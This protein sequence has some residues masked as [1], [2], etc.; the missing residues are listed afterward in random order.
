MPFFNEKPIFLIFNCLLIRFWL[1]YIFVHIP[2]STMTWIRVYF[3]E[4]RIRTTEWAIYVINCWKWRG[5]LRRDEI[6][7]NFVMS[8]LIII[9]QSISSLIWLFTVR[10]TEARLSVHKIPQKNERIQAGIK[11]REATEKDERERWRWK[12]V[13]QIIN[14]PRAFS[15]VPSECFTSTQLQ[16]P[17]H[18]WALNFCYRLR[19]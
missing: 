9:F 12:S 4:I 7:L 3:N 2:I 15:H 1:E 13:Q 8:T 19:Q 11:F 6:C 5:S 18:I 16:K 14:F 17:P 10:R